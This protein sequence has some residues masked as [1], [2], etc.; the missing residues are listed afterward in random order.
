M[1]R[2]V[3]RPD[4]A[5]QATWASLPTPFKAAPAANW[6][7]TTS[8]IT[9]IDAQVSARHHVDI[10]VAEE[11]LA[12]A[13][14]LENSRKTVAV[15]AQAAADS[16]RQGT[17]RAREALQRSRAEETKRHRGE[18][19]AATRRTIT[20]SATMRSA[21]TVTSTAAGTSSA[22]QDAFSSSSTPS[23]A[24]ALRLSPT[25]QPPFNEVA[26]PERHRW[27]G[28]RAF[29]QV[30]VASMAR[31]LLSIFTKGEATAGVDNARAL[32]VELP[33]ERLLFVDGAW[34]LMR[35]DKGKHIG[36][37]RSEWGC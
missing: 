27:S 36:G 31:N 11:A 29:L 33:E 4:Q 13:E 24:L 3:P 2:P 22:Q 21:P 7:L 17:A 14:E 30:S 16:A 32:L 19:A 8:S 26:F 23:A 34:K 25:P 18:A 15:D 6:P 10:T 20:T 28:D 1:S 12:T 37:L 35:D 5:P 9:E